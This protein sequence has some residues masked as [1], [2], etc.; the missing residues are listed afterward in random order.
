M[1]PKVARAWWGMS[2]PTLCSASAF[3]ALH[4]QRVNDSHIK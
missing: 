4:K 2:R 3:Q 1:V